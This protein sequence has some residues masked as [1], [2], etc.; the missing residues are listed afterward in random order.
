MFRDSVHCLAKV[1]CDLVLGSQREVDKC[2]VCGGDGSSCN[3]PSYNWNKRASGSC[4][5]SCGGGEW[6]G[7]ELRV[8]D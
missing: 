4:S 3:K 2:G 5:A 6:E 8:N 1:G 7:D